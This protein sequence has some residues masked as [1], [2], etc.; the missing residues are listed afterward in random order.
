MSGVIADL[1]HSPFYSL[2]SFPYSSALAF[3][4]SQPSLSVFSTWF[5]GLS[6]VGARPHPHPPVVWVKKKKNSRR[7]KCRYGK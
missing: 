1:L 3:H 2:H 4:S 7:K 6:M 5:S